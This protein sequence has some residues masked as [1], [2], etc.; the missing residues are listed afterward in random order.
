M[1]SESQL[2]TISGLVQLLHVSAT[3]HRISIRKA[4]RK[5]QHLGNPKLGLGLGATEL[6][7]ANWRRGVTVETRQRVSQPMWR[8]AYIFICPVYATQ[9][10]GVTPYGVTKL[11][12]FLK[13]IDIDS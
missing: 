4:S 11:G 6:N 13:C 7:V 12:Y 1:I 5:N 10:R 3:Q 2:E 8:A 9:R